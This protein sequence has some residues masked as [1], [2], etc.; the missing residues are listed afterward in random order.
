MTARQPHRLMITGAGG[1]TGQYV[2][3]LALQAGYECIAL[4]PPQTT[5][6][7]NL[8]LSGVD[9]VRADL[10]DAATLQKI[11]QQVRPD[12]VI[13]LAAVAFVGYT[14]IT[15][16]YQ[17]N[18]VG[19]INLLEALAQH[20]DGV[21]RILL[22]SSANIYGNADTLPIRESHPPRP[23]NDYA[24]S[25]YA[26]ELA[27]GLRGSLPVVVVRPFNYTGV[28]Q[29]DSFLLAKIVSAYRQSRRVIRLGNLQVAR[30]F[31]DVRD[32]ADAYL[33]LLQAD[34]ASGVYNICSG[35]SVALLQII[36]MMNRLAGYTM[37]VEVDSALVRRNDIKDLY[38]SDERLRACIGAWRQH[39][40]E[41]TLHWMLT[42]PAP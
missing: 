26:M 37:Q 35:R 18:V 15:Q 31:S 17:T 40:L 33:S 10:L 28:G 36:E 34:T 23:L 29:S 16:I 3:A 1:F 41:D 2:Q 9:V 24:V 7:P 8:C 6:E 30:D 27:A 19:T 25:K 11:V 38:G 13:H 14:D 20:G 12:Y 5:S 32:V 4:L 22:A 39:E 42:T 21:Q